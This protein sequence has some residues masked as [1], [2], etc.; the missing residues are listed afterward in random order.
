MAELFANALA[1]EALTGRWSARLAP[2]F[3]NFARVTGGRV[4]DVG[5]GTGSLVKTLAERDPR[6]E[7]IGIDLARPFI[8]YARTRFSDPRIAFER[9][10]ALAMPFAPGSFDHTLSLLVLMFVPEPEKAAAEMCRVTRA[11][12]TV[13]ACTWDR[14]GLEMASIFWEEAVRLD[15]AAAG[16]AD[17]PRHAN[18]PGEL[19][20]LWRAAG[21]A[22][23]EETALEIQTDFASFDD[24]WQ[25]YLRGV[26]P[27]GVYVAS[28]A[29]EP[30]ETLRQA[31][32]SR[33]LSE[34]ADGPFSLRARAWAVRGR[35]PTR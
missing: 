34:R 23:I 6:L 29:A 15:P 8:E 2:L 24:Y 14:D 12:G 3:A 18:R 21:L 22:D 31:L 1:Y 17:R 25:P 11:G 28:L 19:A 9:A 20:A 35:V 30:R 16:R 13:A 27:P 32:R 33:L 7:I 4:L 5:C 26:A 10:S